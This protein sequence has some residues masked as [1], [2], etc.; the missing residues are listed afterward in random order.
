MSREE[1]SPLYYSMAVTVAI[2]FI[3]L[4]VQFRNIKTSVLIMTTMP[5]CIIGASFGLLATGYPFSVTALIG[6]ISLMGIIVRNGIIYVSFAEELRYEHGHSL[7]EAAIM[8]A[9]RRMRPI[10]LTSCAAAVG[11]IP[12]IASRSPLWGPMGAVICFGLVFGMVLSLVVLPVLY[13]LF[14]RNDFNKAEESVIA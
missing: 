3:I 1:M 12:M 2:I 14:H 11:V 7:E 6:L 9:K 8:A 13:Y 5:L 10:F 4:L